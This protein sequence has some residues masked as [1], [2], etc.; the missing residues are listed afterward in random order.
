MVETENNPL[1]IIV[2]FRY[3]SYLKNNSFKIILFNKI[4]I[5]KNFK[6]YNY[7]INKN[8]EIKFKLINLLFNKNK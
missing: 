8:N 4:T 2:K 7:K 6:N 3:K 1:N 5:K